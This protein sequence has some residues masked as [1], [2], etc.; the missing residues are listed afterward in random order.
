LH[1]L[2]PNT[3]LRENSPKLLGTL[4]PSLSRAADRDGD[5]DE[6]ADGD[7]G[8]RGEVEEAPLFSLLRYPEIPFASALAVEPIIRLI[9][10]LRSGNPLLLVVSGEE[11]GRERSSREDREEDDDRHKKRKKSKHSD[12]EKAKGWVLSVVTATNQLWGFNTFCSMSVSTY[13]CVVL[14]S[15]PLYV[16]LLAQFLIAPSRRVHM[17][18]CNE[19][20]LSFGFDVC[21]CVC[22][23]CREGFEG[24]TFQREG[25]EQ[26]KRQGCSEFNEPYP[27]FHWP[28]LNK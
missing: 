5:E 1:P 19:V 3:R 2:R 4:L 21:V 22:L 23:H 14:F 11:E 28:L 25:E 18:M 6:A 16:R 12:R 8:R 15:E 13:L 20:L 26:E 10:L 7:D 17:I 24:E 9:V 27:L